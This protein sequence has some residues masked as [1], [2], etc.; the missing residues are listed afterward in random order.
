MY[1]MMNLSENGT[2]DWKSSLL[3]SYKILL[4]SAKQHLAKQKKQLKQQKRTSGQPQVQMK[5]KTVLESIHAD[6]TIRK[7]NLPQSKQ[8]K[9][10]FLKYKQSKFQNN[11]FDN[12]NFQRSNFRNNDNQSGYGQQNY[13]KPNHNSPPQRVI[14]TNNQLN[15]TEQ[16]QSSRKPTRQQSKHTIGKK[17]IKQ[18][19]T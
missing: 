18:P 12:N 3:P 4:I 7:E 8:K 6:Q 9:I 14:Q 2:K 15:S 5:N 16:N 11:N 19:T 1:T 13:T 10:H 17:K